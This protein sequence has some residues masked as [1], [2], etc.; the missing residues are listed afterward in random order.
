MHERLS[1]VVTR[2]WRKTGI[3]QTAEK[4]AVRG[5]NSF[6][7]TR[8]VASLLQGCGAAVVT[9]FQTAVFFDRIASRFDFS[10]EK[11]LR[12][13][14]VDFL[15]EKSNETVLDQDGSEFCKLYLI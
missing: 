14:L 5:T 4:L 1:I 13:L 6:A 7:H 11:C 12:G 15:L 9:S 8:T 2:V 3:E 10:I